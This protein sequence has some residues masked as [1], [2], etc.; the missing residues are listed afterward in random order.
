MAQ[1]IHATKL[2]QSEGKVLGVRLQGRVTADDY[3]EIIPQMEQIIDQYGALR[4]L[5][6]LK[7]I[8]GMTP[9]AIWE[10]LKFDARHFRDCERMAIVG[11][12][13]WEKWLA[14]LSKPFVSGEV[15]FFEF[16]DLREAW[17]WRK[18]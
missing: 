13:D 10:D 3:A 11:D 9:G 14:T 4:L 18:A 6:E 15:R 1:A 5:V 17:A 16:H 2:D 8:Q 7:G 12:K